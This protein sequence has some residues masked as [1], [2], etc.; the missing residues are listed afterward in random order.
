[1]ISEEISNMRFNYEI[2]VTFC[3]PYT[4]IDNLYTC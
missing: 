4:L 1:M 2:P 3:F